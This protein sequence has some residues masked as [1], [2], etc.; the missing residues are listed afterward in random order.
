MTGVGATIHDIVIEGA[1][2]ASLKESFTQVDIEV[3]NN[4]TN[5]GN[6]M[7][8]GRLLYIESTGSNITL[9]NLYLYGAYVREYGHPSDTT[10]SANIVT[11]RGDDNLLIDNCRAEHGEGGFGMTG[12]GTESTNLRIINSKVY[13]CSTAIKMGTTAGGGNNGV[14]ISGNDLDGFGF[15][16]G[17]PAPGQHHCDGIQTFTSHHDGTGQRNL[18]ISYNR[19]GPDLGKYGSMNAH[20]YIED[21]VCGVDAYNNFLTSND[22]PVNNT[23]EGPKKPGTANGFLTITPNEV[24][25]SSPTRKLNRVF[26]NTIYQKGGKGQ[27]LSVGFAH[28]FGNIVIDSEAYV[29]LSANDAGDPVLGPTFVCDYNIYYDTQHGVYEFGITGLGQGIKNQDG[30]RAD[31]GHDSHSIFHVNPQVNFAT[32]AIP[33]N[34][35]AVGFAPMQTIFNDDIVRKIRS[36]PWDTGAYEF[37][38]G[39]TPTPAPTPTPTPAPTPTPIPTPSHQLHTPTPTPTPVPTPTPTPV[40]TSITVTPSTLGNL[41]WSGEPVSIPYTSPTSATW[42]VTDYWGK[43][44]A[45][46]AGS[47]IEP[48]TTK[49]GW[50]EVEIRAG[51]TSLKTSFGIVTW[52]LIANTPNAPWGA[53]AHFA[54]FTDQDIIP[55]MPRLGLNQVGDDHYW[56]ATENP[57]G[58]YIFPAK[59]ES[60]MAAL[61]ANGLRSVTGLSWANLLYVPAG[62][63]P[64]TMPYDEAQRL[65]YA[66]YAMAILNHYTNPAKDVSVWNEVNGGTFV[67]GPA[68]ADPVRF[69]KL[70][71]QKVWEVIKP[72]HPKVKIC[73]FNTV[74]I[75]HGFL[76]DS[77][78]AGALPYCDAVGIHPYRGYPDGVD[79][80]VKILREM[81]NANGGQDKGIWAT[82]F[83]KPMP[84]PRREG[85]P[86]LA[87][88][89]TLMLSEGVERF[90]WYQLLDDGQFPTWGLVGSS[91]NPRGKFRPHPAAIAYAVLIRKL[92]GAIAQGRHDTPASIYAMKFLG[93]DQKPMTVL[94]SN[95]PVSVDCEIPDKLILL[96]DIMG[97][98][99]VKLP[100]SGK[101][102]LKLTADVQYVNGAITSITPIGNDLL[103]DSISGT[104][105]IQGQNGW[106]YGTS[107]I[108]PTSAYNHAAFVPMAWATWGGYDYRWIKPGGLYPF[109][110]GEK[111][112]P[113]GNTGAVRR[114]TSNNYDGFATLS[115]KLVRGTG[116]DGNGIRIFVDGLQVYNAHILPGQTI[117]YNIPDVVIRTG[118][119]VDFTLNSWGDSSF[120]AMGF[121]S[122]IIATPAP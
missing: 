35:N 25:R 102:R 78:A 39:P 61:K 118:S 29:A 26:N 16:A 46:G 106:S 64:F 92:T 91:P 122:Q 77:F 105:R 53:V 43:V 80:E 88:L 54:Q 83:G 113:L 65:G 119:Q 109:A 68:T 7:P 79:L 57:K 95:R 48:G 27:G 117:N 19:I 41:F 9:K 89:V 60:Y 20:I 4:G 103:A 110:G 33:A 34:S 18:V 67:Q 111:M 90:H 70:M 11:L 55:L 44:V 104:G 72:V 28:V 93:R 17:I 45:S 112:H 94:W 30:W 96:T 87:Q 32:A 81:M 13:A 97:G 37:A 22:F 15:W 101:V 38:A 120:D 58:N 52:I 12:V 85:A 6:K 2:T 50:Y 31:T 66:S 115:G 59:F 73:G 14:V 63:H 69:Y 121:T 51:A 107:P 114:W 21:N 76:R 75:A 3:F 99:T 100:T 42:T 24:A 40:P 116:G 10:A 82:E 56:N 86:Y 8:N 84:D 5:M 1:N 74:L 98:V 23:P 49:L 71:L 36:V 62:S 108:T 47:P